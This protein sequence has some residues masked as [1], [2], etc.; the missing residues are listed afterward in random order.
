M[1]TPISLMNRICAGRP[2]DR[3][4]R[5]VAI[6]CHPHGAPVDRRRLPPGQPDKPPAVTPAPPARRPAPEPARTRVDDD[7]A[8]P[9]VRPA[10]PELR[11]RV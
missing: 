11:G 7:I 5:R 6:T 1:L 3:N 9:R 8:S 4:C 10:P 2:K